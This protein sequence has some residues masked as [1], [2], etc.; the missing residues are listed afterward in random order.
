MIPLAICETRATALRI[1]RKSSVMGSDCD[2]TPFD[3]PCIGGH[4]LAPFHLESSTQ[5]DV[6][7]QAIYDARMAAIEKLKSAGIDD[8]TIKAAMN[9]DDE[10]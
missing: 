3:A 8:E 1:G 7:N 2:V 5:E 4:L 6:N 10:Y 9:R